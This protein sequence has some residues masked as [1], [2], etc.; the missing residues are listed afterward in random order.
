MLSVWEKEYFLNWRY[1]RWFIFASVPGLA[2]AIGV[3]VALSRWKW[4]ILGFVLTELLVYLG[5]VTL[6]SGTVSSNLGT[7]FRSSEPIRY[8][9]GVSVILAGYVLVMAGIWIGK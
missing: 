7:H 9:I 8:W 1:V 5:F 3:A 2:S 6:C 4:A